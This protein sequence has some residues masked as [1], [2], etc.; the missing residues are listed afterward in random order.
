MAALT[1][2][3][4]YE[5]A[6]SQIAQSLADFLCLADIVGGSAIARSGLLSAN[7]GVRL[8]STGSGFDRDPNC[9]KWNGDDSFRAGLCGSSLAA[10]PTITN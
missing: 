9:G 6:R 2:G 7:L 4:R 3:G 10:S 1:H 8:L 5:V